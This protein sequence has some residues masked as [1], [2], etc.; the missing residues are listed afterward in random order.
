MWGK[1]ERRHE[2]GSG[3]VE[4]RKFRGLEMEKAGR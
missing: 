4:D 1:V 2:Q 3:E